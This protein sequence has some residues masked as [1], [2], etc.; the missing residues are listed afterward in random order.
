MI[1]ISYHKLVRMVSDMFLVLLHLCSGL[2]K[3][4]SINKPCV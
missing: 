1:I 3:D 4:N 2:E